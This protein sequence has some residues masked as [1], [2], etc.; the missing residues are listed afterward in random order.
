VLAASEAVEQEELHVG[1]VQ[2]AADWVLVY[3]LVRRRVGQER[4]AH[5]RDFNPRHELGWAAHLLAVGA[6]LNEME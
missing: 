5:F 2:A 1:L 4:L 3:G 6:H